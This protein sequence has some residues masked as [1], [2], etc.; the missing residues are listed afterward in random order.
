M[1]LL[2]RNKKNC[3]LKMAAFVSNFF[4]YLK[5]KAVIMGRPRSFYFVLVSE[6]KERTLKGD[7]RGKDLARLLT[8]LD[9]AI[10]SNIEHNL[11][12]DFGGLLIKSIK[13][14]SVSIACAGKVQQYQSYESLISNMN[15]D[16]SGLP[17]GT[18][19]TLH[20]IREFNT[21]YDARLELRDKA[22][23]SP[24]AIIHKF[25]K[26]NPIEDSQV[27]TT[28]TTLYGKISAISGVSQ[29]RVT[30]S[31]INFSGQVNFLVTPTE[32]KALGARY[33]E[34]IGVLGE[35]EIQLPDRI[36]RSFRKNRILEYSEGDIDKNINVIRSRYGEFFNSIQDV[37]TFVTEQ[38]G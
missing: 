15:G 24:R 32:S 26:K 1:F 21:A 25:E 20:K 8:L 3:Y 34:A 10:S 12:N 30:L 33:G 27:I 37:E 5:H 19:V 16:E 13:P 22:K 2:A 23:S 17:K 35:A 14:G 29:I 6:N 7:L 36:I 18:L 28:T 31:L 11:G 4:N 9:D 38:R